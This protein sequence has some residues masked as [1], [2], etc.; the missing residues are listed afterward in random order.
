[1]KSVIFI[2]THD[3]YFDEI[4]SGM[5]E[6]W[7]LSVLRPPAGQSTVSLLQ[8]NT[9]DVILLD[10][11]QQGPEMINL[12]LEAK[13]ALPDIE[14]IIINT[15]DNIKNSMEAMR[16][17]ADDEIMAPF[18]STDLQKRIND[19]CRR[20]RAKLRKSGKRALGEM[21][22]NVMNAAVFA[23]AGEFETAIELFNE[24]LSGHSGIKRKNIQ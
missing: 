22:S 13:K 23:Q 21:F 9:V 17:G 24:D 12:L 18:D 6:R 19:A 16:A 3:I 11:R 15:A 10:I 4:L 7:G 1:M 14:V 8:K 20:R 5:L 2:E